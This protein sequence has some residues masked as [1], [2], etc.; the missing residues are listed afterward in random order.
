MAS[1]RIAMPI[2]VKRSPAATMT[3]AATATPMLMSWTPVSSIPRVPKK[4]N[5]RPE[6][7][8][9]VKNFGPNTASRMFCRIRPDQSV[10][11]SMPNR[12]TP[13]RTNRRKMSRFMA[14]ETTAPVAA[15]TMRSSHR[16]PPA[17][18][19]A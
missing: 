19:T 5:S 16:P 2:R 13:C 4:V 6:L 7:T 8:C 18:F 15:P 11:M 17:A 12:L 10:T 14:T 1:A 9:N 3:T